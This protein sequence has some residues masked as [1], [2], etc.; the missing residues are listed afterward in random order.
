MTV[1]I[2]SK[3]GAA[4]SYGEFLGQYEYHEDKDS[5]VQKSTEQSNEF[6][7]AHYLFDRADKWIVMKDTSRMGWLL[8]SSSGKTPPTSTSRWQ[9]Y[10]RNHKQLHD[11]PT[12][13]VTSGP[14]PPLPRQFTVTNKPGCQPCAG[15][16]AP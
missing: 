3:G 4:Q 10:C 9:F 7:E 11:D 15:A 16:R 12:L 5:Y 14:L 2:S 13:K 1:V 6:F 8:T